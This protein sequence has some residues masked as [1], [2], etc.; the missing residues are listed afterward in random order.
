MKIWIGCAVG[1]WCIIARCNGTALQS[2][3]VPWGADG[4]EL[5]YDAGMRITPSVRAEEESITLYFH[6]LLKTGYRV[7]LDDLDRKKESL[8]LNDWMYYGLMRTGVEAIFKD[9]SRLE[10]ELITWFMLSHA[11]YDTRLTFNGHSAY[12]YVFVEE[13]VYDAPM[14]EDN[15]RSFYY[16]PFPMTCPVETEPVYMLP[17]HAMPGGRPL[18]FRQL[19]YPAWKV[20]PIEKTLQIRTPDTLFDISVTIDGSLVEVM[21]EHPVLSEKTYF[22]MPMSPILRAT[23]LPQLASILKEKKE[24]EALEILLAFTRSSFAYEKDE[25]V[26]GR[27]KPMIPDEVFFYP[28]SDCEDRAVLFYQLV[29]SLL[30]LPMVVVSFA[31]HITIGVAASWRCRD[32]VRLNGVEYCICDPTGPAHSIETGIWPKGYEDR[33]FEIIQI[34][35]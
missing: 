34:R 13:E 21:Q 24:R 3:L 27:S 10:R 6:G 4:V 2:I 11:G 28:Y 25:V 33:P 15:F 22:E 1:F 14:L 19:E 12:L 8:R 23:L 35:R 17:F 9:H 30:N 26:F 18:S 31:D 20:S 16:L 32:A 29:D 5:K 7:L